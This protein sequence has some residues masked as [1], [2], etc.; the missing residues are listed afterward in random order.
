MN[1]GYRLSSLHRPW[2]YYSLGGVMGLNAHSLPV[3]HLS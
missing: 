2:L 3:V 1:G